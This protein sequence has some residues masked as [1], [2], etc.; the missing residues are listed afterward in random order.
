MSDLVD[1]SQ[2]T[3]V[4]DRDANAAQSREQALPRLD[5]RSMRFRKVAPSLSARSKAA[6]C[7]EETPC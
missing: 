6:F 1:S 3:A 4:R 7:S 2:E 5:E